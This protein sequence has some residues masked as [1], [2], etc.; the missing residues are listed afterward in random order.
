MSLQTQRKRKQTQDA[1]LDEE[2]VDSNVSKIQELVQ[3]TPKKQKSMRNAETHNN[4]KEN[5]T[6]KKFDGSN[7]PTQKVPKTPRTPS[8]VY[9]DAKALFRRCATPKKLIGRLKERNE[10][11]D[12]IVKHVYNQIPGSLYVSG[13]PGTGKTALIQEVVRDM[14]TL[15]L[16]FP[17]KTLFFN[18]MN[19]ADPKQIFS[20]LASGWGFKGETKDIKLLSSYLIPSKATKKSPF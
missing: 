14:D 1:T 12:F 19:V 8:S 18:C 9:K 15:K 16:G 6:P 5:N 4:E 13:C 2:K 10:L 17:L 20:H 7:T 3:L 11:E